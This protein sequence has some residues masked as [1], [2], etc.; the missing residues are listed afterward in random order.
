MDGY[1]I[2]PLDTEAVRRFLDSVA[3]DVDA[4]AVTGVFSPAFSDQERT[5]A[6]LVTSVLGADCPVS[7]SHEIGSLGL[8]ERENATVLNAALYGVA[9]EVTKALGEVLSDRKLDV[10]S[11][12][13]QNDGTLMALEYATRYPVLTIGSGPADS[14]RGAAF[15]SGVEDAIV[16]DVGGTSTDLGVLVRGSR[17]VVRGR[18]HRRGPHQ[19]PYAGHLQHRDRRRDGRRRNAESAQVGPESVALRIATEGLAFGGSTRDHHR[20]RPGRRARLGGLG[21]PQWLAAGDS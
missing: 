9:G 11:F 20:R 4:I 19:L 13:A 7:M 3:G 15:L 14:I 12:F 18:G 6:E 8:V 17:A 21:R 2:A 16:A 5:V 1:P 10:S